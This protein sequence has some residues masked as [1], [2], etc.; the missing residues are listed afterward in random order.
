MNL[1]TNQDDMYWRPIETA[2][3]DQ[4]ILLLRPTKYGG[5]RV[6]IGYFES[7]KHHSKPRPYWESMSKLS[8]FEKRTYQPTYWMPLPE[9]P[10]LPE[11]EKLT[12]ADLRGADLNGANLG[13][14]Y[15]TGGKK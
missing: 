4:N 3:K 2:P 7:E 12:G 10:S 9:T 5:P 14:A 6:E 8:M 11:A 1:I 13:D 15:W